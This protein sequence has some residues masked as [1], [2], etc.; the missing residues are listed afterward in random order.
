MDKLL[1]AGFIREAA[2]PDWL[3]NVVMVKKANEK[4]RI[5]INYTDLNVACP[6]DSF[7]LSKI[8]QLVDATSGHR[9]LSFMDA[10]AGYNQIC[11]A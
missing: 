3:A 8:D 9:F 5:C 6:N 7:L 11:M 2:Y 1:E 4:W 10:F